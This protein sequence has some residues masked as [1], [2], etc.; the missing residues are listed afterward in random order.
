MLGDQIVQFFSDFGTAG[1]LLALFVIFIIDSTLFPMVPELFL[2][3]MYAANPSP[4]WG[5]L[6]VAVAL[7]A[8]GGGNTLLYVTVKK[9]GVPPFIEK[10]MKKYSTLMIAQDETMLLINRIAPVLPYTGAFIAINRWRYDRAMTYILLGGCV[11]FSVLVMLSDAFYIWFERGTAQ[12]ATFLLIV[13]TLALGGV[14]AYVR[15]RKME[16][17]GIE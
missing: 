1:M 5:V 13:C 12:N 14:L 7:I 9:F 17:K 2:L 4:G 10:V 3:I 16:S 15:K 11:K 8:I 6:L